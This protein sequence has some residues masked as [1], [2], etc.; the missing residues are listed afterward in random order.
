MFVP[1][2]GARVSPKHLR[3]LVDKKK[4]KDAPAIDTDGELDSAAEPDLF[5]YYGAPRPTLTP[6]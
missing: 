3:V 2:D 5:A 4:A 1:L 6:A